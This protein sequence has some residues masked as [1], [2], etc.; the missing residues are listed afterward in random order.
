MTMTN[1]SPSARGRRAKFTPQAIEKIKELVAQGVSREE[2]ASLL[3][4]TVGSL[5]VTC[6]RLGISLRRKILYSGPTPHMRDPK[7][8]A[9]PFRGA[10]GV[11]YMREQKTEEV[12]QTVVDTG[13]SAK[14]AIMMRHRGK[15]VATDVPLTSRAIGELGLIATS[16]DVSIAEVVGQVL[17]GAIKK[18]MIEEILGD[19]VPSSSV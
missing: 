10:V 6:S 4:V 16:R 13:R 3:G 19:D 2:I 1:A 12:P 8:K 5:Q 14:I 11:A 7:G 17:A 18:G 9:I 15:E